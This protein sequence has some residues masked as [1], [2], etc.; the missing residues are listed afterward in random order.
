[1]LMSLEPLD[2]ELLL[3]GALFDEVLL[4]DVVDGVFGRVV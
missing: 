1:M 4:L 2:E 3:N